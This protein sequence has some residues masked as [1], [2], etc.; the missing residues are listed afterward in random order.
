MVYD[1]GEFNTAVISKLIQKCRCY[2]L[3]ET[4]VETYTYYQP[5]AMYYG[6]VSFIQIWWR[7]HAKEGLFN[8][9]DA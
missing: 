1:N 8:L 5:V 9:F 3:Q 2:L 4:L 6:G 7:F